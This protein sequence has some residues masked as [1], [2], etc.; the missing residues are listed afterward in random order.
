[1]ILTGRQRQALEHDG[2]VC[3]TA[4]AGTGKTS[5][6]V[7]IYCDRLANRGLRPAEI[8][9]VTFTDLAAAD[10]RARCAE[11]LSTREGE[12]FA[13]ART[14]FTS[15]RISTIHAFAR[16]VCEEL[17]CEAGVAPNVGVLDE[18]Q[19]TRLVGD[20]IDRLFLAPP[21]AVRTP[22]VRLLSRY[23][24]RTLAQ[25]LRS[26]IDK[27]ETVR[28]FLLE[29][30][31]DE[32]TA[33]E[34]WNLTVADTRAGAVARV[35]GNPEVNAALRTLA[36]CADRHA[37]PVDA[38]T[39]YL[40]AATPHIGALITEAGEP[41]S[42]LLALQT[43]TIRRRGSQRGFDND[44]EM[45][46]AACDRL[47]TALETEREL[48]EL[49]EG[50]EAFGPTLEVLRDLGPVFL[51]LDDACEAEKAR[52][53][54]L[55]FND[56]IVRAHRVLSGNVHDCRGFSQRYRYLL[57]DEFQDTD[58]R[59][60]ALFL[61][62][63]N[64]LV[65]TDLNVAVV[66]DHK[67][68]I[69]GFRGADVTG[70]SRAARMIASCGGG[71]TAALDIN[72]RSTPAV[73]AFVNH[74]FSRL[75]AGRGALDG[76]GYDSI[77]PC[78]DR[79]GDHGRVEVLL[80]SDEDR[81]MEAV[82]RRCQAIVEEGWPVYRDERGQYARNPRKALYGDIAILL[83]RKTRLPLLERALRERRVPYHVHGGMGLYTRQEVYDL[84][85]LLAAL[86]NG[87]DD[88]ALYSALRSPF[89]GHTASE[90]ASAAERGDQTLWEWLRSDGRF[91]ATVG[92]LE[93][94]R[95]RSV[96]VPPV[97]LIR[98]LLLDSEVL[99]RYGALDAEGRR[100]VSNLDLVA[101]RA[102]N[103]AFASALSLP[104]FVTDLRRAIAENERDA[105][106]EADDG[107]DNVVRIMTVHKAKGLEFPI[108]F[109]PDLAAVEQDRA[110]PVLVDAAAGIALAV[111]DPADSFERRPDPAYS[112]LRHIRSEQ[113]RAEY[114][115][116]F[117]VAATRAQDHLIL[118]GPRY[119]GSSRGPTW[120]GWT[121]QTLGL[122]DAAIAA[123]QID[124]LDGRGGHVGI[125]IR[126]DGDVDPM[127]GTTAG[128]DE[129]DEQS[130]A[131]VAP[132]PAAD[133]YPSPVSVS[134][135]V[136]AEGAPGFGLDQGAGTVPRGLS[137]ARWG[138]LLHEVCMGREPIRALTEA[139]CTDPDGELRC[140][141]SR[142]RFRA[143]GPIAAAVDVWYELPFTVSIGGLAVNGAIDC[144]A[145]G[146][147]G[148]WTVI[149]LKSG[150]SADPVTLVERY[151]TQVNL[152]RRA[153]ES[154]LGVEWV[155][156]YL[157]AVETGDLVRVPVDPD[158]EERVVR[159]AARLR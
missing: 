153:A 142:D 146:A 40:T 22:L 115:R 74:V 11:A 27:R 125:K 45:F 42:H 53:N 93:V 58:P 137:A 77:M 148:G 132:V 17:P 81:D 1:M 36:I 144:L 113:Q 21:A 5:L 134:A 56:L 37:G 14:E 136:W 98:E 105:E 94:W 143:S 135:L 73:L 97:V 35:L 67:Q 75:L 139:G 126:Y 151:G 157:Y 100:C 86:V 147:D 34:R 3:V 119:P 118:C 30:N 159:L 31:R 88:I 13:R 89:L 102:R 51:A 92:R 127:H 145:R 85:N 16:Q 65:G 112:C 29:C 80:V 116:I 130:E 140:L 71:D 131:F 63:A 83:R 108:V 133:R 19:Y 78:D 7:E 41:V 128:T 32:R 4:G 109:L 66:G 72:F 68:S 90:L 138:T 101:Q 61:R 158:L 117:Y 110:P 25:I 82:A 38:G 120:M 48:L 44:L 24:A 8:L 43:M 91:G 99:G 152:Y 55:S 64:D 60:F 154:L 50:N 114:R 122:D 111:P 46:R 2:S 129:G 15:A 62:L 33:L 76:P 54:A 124:I 47:K 96:R 12:V 39:Q 20:A 70:F 10:M 69:Y 150:L 84:C 59:Q 79:A 26:L 107:S 87:R 149:D 23:G 52:R 123:G 106:A 28:D 141:T 6:L 156:A 57:I 104:A 155:D 95:R 103:P 18:R 9:A 121:I 49:P